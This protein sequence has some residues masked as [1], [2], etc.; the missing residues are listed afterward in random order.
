M[1]LTSLTEP[2]LLIALMISSDF[3]SYLLHFEQLELW[4]PPDLILL[5]APDNFFHPLKKNVIASN[6]VIIVSSVSFLVTYCLDFVCCVGSHCCWLYRLLV[7]VLAPETFRQICSFN[8]GYG[9]GQYSIT[10]NQCLF[11]FV[12]IF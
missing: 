8:D 6:R 4:E 3:V 5:V 1:F 11:D 10:D 9:Y 12:H 2:F 7:F